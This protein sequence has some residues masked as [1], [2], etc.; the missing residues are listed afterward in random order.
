MR[1]SLNKQIIAYLLLAVI[2]LFILYAAGSYFFPGK[3]G[4]R[5]ITSVVTKSDIQDT[6]LASGTLEALQQVSVGAQVSGQLK[7]LKVALGDQVK[8]G[9]LIAEIDSLP[10][11]NAFR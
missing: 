4:P 1:F 2:L 11:Q 8:K 9:Q 3:S 5:F 7:S 6:V 10:Q